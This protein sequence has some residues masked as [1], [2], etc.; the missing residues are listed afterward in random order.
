MIIYA[1]LSLMPVGTGLSGAGW[2]LSMRR[3]LSY[4]NCRGGESYQTLKKPSG[5]IRTPGL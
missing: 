4:F 5:I 3:A 1:V 2:M